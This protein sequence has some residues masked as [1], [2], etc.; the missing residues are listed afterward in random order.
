MPLTGEPGFK[1]F[2]HRKLQAIGFQMKATENGALRHVRVIVTYHALADINHAEIMDFQA[3]LECLRRFQDRIETA[4]SKKFDRIGRDVSDYEG[5]P[6][7]L[8]M[9][10]DP[11]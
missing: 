3:A 8:L 6:T 10:S 2:F 1:P 7:V 11:I 4:A 9:T 5:F